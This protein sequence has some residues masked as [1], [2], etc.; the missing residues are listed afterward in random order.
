LYTYHVEVSKWQR[1]NSHATFRG[2]HRIFSLP[3]FPTLNTQP[4]IL[5]S[6]T[7]GPHPELA[8]AAPHALLLPPLSTI[9]AP[10][11]HSLP[12]PS[13]P[14]LSINSGLTIHDHSFLSHRAFHHHAIVN[15]P[16]PVLPSSNS[17]SLQGAFKLMCHHSF[18]PLVNN[19]P[20][21]TKGMYNPDS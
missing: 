11:H 7:Q 12:C 13:P 1:I 20:L 10:L 17:F 18:L 3:P 15:I 19:L 6:K 8:I 2:R 14:P 21:L 9:V 4:P 5:N 16:P